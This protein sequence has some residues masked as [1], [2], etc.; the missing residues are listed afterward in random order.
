M[1]KE[2]HVSLFDIIICLSDALDLISPAVINHHKRVAYIALNIAA[3]MGLSKEEQTGLIIAGI[4]HDIGAF[5]LKERLSSL[6]FEL[7]FPHQHAEKGYFLLKIF[8][9]FARVAPLVRYHHVPWNNGEGSKFKGESVPLGSHILHLADRIDALINKQQEVLGQVKEI[10][11]KINQYSG[12]LFIPDLVE[13]FNRLAE[14]E[15]FWLD[16][17]SSSINQVLARKARFITVGLDLEELL[18][19]TRLF[20]RI[21]DFRSRFTATHSSG[22]AATA[23]ALAKI[24]GMSKRECMMMRIA[25]YLHDLGKLAVPAEILEKPGKLTGDEFNIIKGHTFYTYRILENVGGLEEI[26]T[27]ASFHH[28][29]LDGKGYPFHHKADDLS[30]GARIMAVADVFTA[31]TEDRPYRK[32]MTKDKA[33]HVLKKMVNNSAL[34]PMIVSSLI[35]NYEEINSIRIAAQITASKEYEEFEKQTA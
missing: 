15:Y 35:K 14:K 11:E 3:E 32:G 8:E 10:C 19:L 9:P 22:V 27:W 5:S 4:L 16:A 24:M 23:E 13:V 33:L 31:I 30:L 28:E 1:I 25:G 34:D 21:I 18:N 7:D 29:R 6:N 17:V 12:E 26:N 2:L 20:S